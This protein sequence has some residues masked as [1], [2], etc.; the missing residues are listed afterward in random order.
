MNPV[1]SDGDH[2]YRM[3]QYDIDGQSE[4][5]GPIHLNCGQS[6]N[7]KINI[8]PNPNSNE[9]YISI[10]E[11]E[12]KGKA[13]I[14]ILDLQGNVCFTENIQIADGVN[15]YAMNTDLSSGLYILRIHKDSIIFDSKN[16]IIR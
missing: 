1:I 12:N 13:I 6:S 3:I 10:F 5:F 8:Y 7:Q 16:L 2:Y 4:L 14:E 11:I 15:V 9:F